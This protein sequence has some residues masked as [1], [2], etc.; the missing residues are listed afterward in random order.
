METQTK[1]PVLMMGNNA[2][3]RGAIE[4]GVKVVAGYP[5]TPSS[6]ILST[7]A[8]DAKKYD[9]HVEWSTNEKV[10][11][12]VAYGAALSGV[13]A[14]MTTK[15]LGIN[16]LSDALLVS[17][18][19]GVNG[20]LVIV[21]ADD[22]HPF[23]SQNAEDT[24]YYAKLAKI[25]CIEPSNVQEAKDMMLDAFQLSEDLQL[26]VL[27]RVTDRICHAKS[28]AV[29]GEILQLDRKPTFT[30]EDSRYVMIAPNARKRVGWLNQQ[31]DKAA[32]LSENY[33]H[34]K[35]DRAMWAQ[36]G[37]IAA[38]I[39]YEHTVEALDVLDL[40]D[41]VSVLKLGFT[42][43]LPKQKIAS[44][45]RAHQRVLLAEEIEPIIESEVHSIAHQLGIDVQVHGRLDGFVPMEHELT[46][47][48][49]GSSITHILQIDDPELQGLEYNVPEMIRRIP[50]LCAGCPHAASYYALKV[51][52]RMKG[53]GGAVTGDRG[54][55]N[56]GTNP[57]LSAIDTCVCMGASISMAS[58]L[59]HSGVEGPL[60]AVIGDGT[61][62][63]NG[64]HPLIN[65]VHN[66]A[67]ITV[68]ILDNGWT[69]MTG[70]QPNPNTGLN[71]LGEPVPR[72]SIEEIVKA[73]GVKHL[74]VV[75]PY[76]VEET[77]Q[78]ISSA[79][80]QPGPAVVVCRQVCPVQDH[81]IRRKQ[82]D[83]LDLK[84]FT[85]DSDLC[86]G[87]L[88]CV[89][90]IGCPALDVTRGKISINPVHCI[91]CGVCEQICPTKAIKEVM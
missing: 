37:V 7:I 55:Y 20:G 3:A 25:P 38:G 79:M 18:Y 44:F 35:V 48:R 46:P 49:I 87:C 74:Q 62:F 23:S 42:F 28:G 57:P 17:A 68:L 83:K 70:H 82:G 41:K 86:S 24:R 64:I 40:K 14:L 73:C 31:I 21:T 91:G 15:H 88:H 26:P 13:R 80:D 11:Y 77:V 8:K 32:A 22:I 2:I 54:C 47:E 60:V 29:I 56:Q 50:N 1:T 4:A 71:V 59:Y 16:V 66:T 52:R 12:E 27:F 72:V 65:A 33:Y 9:I 5:G 89:N 78:A 6:E 85:V 81:R 69:G 51:A 39:P 76:D 84:M 75:S 19:T 63:H 90:S 34:N 36:M 58:G 10:A 61:F 30:K 43:P 53:G 67:N 45:L